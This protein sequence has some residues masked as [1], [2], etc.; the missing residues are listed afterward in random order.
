MSE[1]CAGI[2]LD[3]NDNYCCPSPLHRDGRV[4][5]RLSNNSKPKDGD[6]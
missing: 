3:P 6:R 5:L 1:R 2:Q 4:E